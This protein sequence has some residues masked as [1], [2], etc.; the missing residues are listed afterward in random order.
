[1]DKIIWL[2]ALPPIIAIAIAIWSKQILPALL[3][4]LLAGSYF[5]HPTLAGG[6]ETTF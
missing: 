4:G 6:F 3:A 1:M 2:S 5:L